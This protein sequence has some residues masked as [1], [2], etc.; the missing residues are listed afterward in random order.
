MLLWNN[1]YHS[2]Q[3]KSWL[4]SHDF[5][6]AVRR[7]LLQ[8]GTKKTWLLRHNINVS[9]IIPNFL[10]LW[11]LKL[12]I[13]KWFLFSNCLL[14]EFW[15]LKF[16]KIFWQILMGGRF[17]RIHSRRKCLRLNMIVKNYCPRLNTHISCRNML[18]ENRWVS[19][20]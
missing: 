9:S 20:V 17:R 11:V 2:K 8:K 5:Y 10:S 6:K 13:K 4:W 16:I 1:L 7:S 15:L 12:S 3:K 14:F 19:D 18:K